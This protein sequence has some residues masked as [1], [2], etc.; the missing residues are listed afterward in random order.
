MRPHNRGPPLGINSLFLKAVEHNVAM[1]S[2]LSLLC[3]VS[4]SGNLMIW[5]KMGKACSS[6]QF[7]NSYMFFAIH[8]KFTSIVM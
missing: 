3:T 6:M 2:E 1:L 7:I 8:K 5:E 4:N